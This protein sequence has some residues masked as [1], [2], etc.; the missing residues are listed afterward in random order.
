MDIMKKDEATTMKGHHK[1]Y[2]KLLLM[3]AKEA[4]IQDPEIRELCRTIISS[5]QAEI[6]QMKAKLKALNK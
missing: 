6:D 2:W 1:N 4:S 3:A 5:Q